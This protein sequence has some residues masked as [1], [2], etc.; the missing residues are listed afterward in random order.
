MDGLATNDN[1]P[2]AERTYSHVSARR[3]VEEPE[4]D[5]PASSTSSSP[6]SSIA[7]HEVFVADQT[8]ALL[9]L[10]TTR[11]T[12][13]PALSRELSRYTT[14]GTTYTSDPSFEV[15][16]EVGSPEDPR[17]WPA[18]YKGIVVFAIAFSTL[19]VVVYSTS[20]TA[21]FEPLKLDLGVTSNTIPTLGVTTYL[22]GLAIGSLV[23]APISETYGRRPVY[24]IALFCFSILVIP[25]ALAKNM[26]TIIVV[27]LLGA[28]AGS[29]T[30]ANA[31][32]TIGDI[33][34]DE[35][36]ALVFSVWSIGP[37]NGPVIGETSSINPLPLEDVR[38]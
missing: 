29:A 2:A 32:G 8:P 3:A 9:T 1:F 38:E 17:N 20:Y 16:F 22:F 23:L 35:Y 36:R 21:T 25:C 33:V 10:Q 26:T 18:W 7:Q 11:A 13:R 28:I 14:H 30:I 24:V 31:P 34:S 19:G 37:M 5:S 4:P 6:P 15:D 27:R 12:A